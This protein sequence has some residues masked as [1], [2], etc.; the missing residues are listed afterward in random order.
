MSRQSLNDLTV[1]IED[2]HLKTNQIPYKIEQTCK[3]IFALRL[4]M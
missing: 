4:E 3:Y 1:S 2:Q